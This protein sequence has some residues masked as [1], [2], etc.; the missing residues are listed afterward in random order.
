VRVLLTHTSTLPDRM[1][2][3][4]RV[5]WELAR[6]LRRNDHEV[7]I[8]VPRVKSG[9][10]G[11][12]VVDGITID[13]YRDPAHSFATLYLPSIALARATL[14]AV[15]R[16]WR[17]DITHAHHS[18]TGLGAGVA[19]ARPLVYTFYGPWYQEFLHEVQNQREMPA[20]KRWTRGLWAPAKA[21]LARRIERAAMRRAQR[22]VVLSRY[23]RQQLAG[24]HGVSGSHV[25]I[26]PGGVDLQHFVPALE[27]RDARRR[28]G[29]P[30][31]GPL[32]FT[33]RRLV[34]RM[35]LESLLQAL[36]HVPDARL[37]IGGRGWLRPRLEASALALGLT[38]RVRFAGFIDDADL[39]LFYQAADLV[40]LPSVALEGFG[41]I[42]LEALAC[43]TPVVATANSGATDVLDSLEPSWIAPDGTPA[44]LAT[45]IVGALR[46]SCAPEVNKRCR[47]HAERYAW[48]RMVARHDELYREL[49]SARA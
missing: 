16:D 44:T 1:G 18:L 5:M 19:G 42:T 25:R 21:A 8:V 26:I 20:L 27:R 3:S 11:R 22:V 39:P 38:D 32:L 12:T 4:E 30:A 40:V 31:D 48:D 37:V 29:L 33:V 15:I 6:G 10:P 14:G 47:V 35:G 43:G 45:T 7:R 41:L 34:P 13:R 23:S 49:V 17:P 28:L 2:G 24:V 36:T 9:V 46:A